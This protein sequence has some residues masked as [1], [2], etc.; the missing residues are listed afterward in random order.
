MENMPTTFVHISPENIKQELDHDGGI[1]YTDGKNVFEQNDDNND[2]QSTY[3]DDFE[4]Q[5]DIELHKLEDVQ[6][7]KLAHSYIILNL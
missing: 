5:I 7:G 4:D 2:S 3:E 1:L 6:T